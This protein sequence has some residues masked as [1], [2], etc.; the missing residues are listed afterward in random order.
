MKFQRWILISFAVWA[1]V[2]VL[3]VLGVRFIF[4]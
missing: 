4:G 3:V 2:V 1:A